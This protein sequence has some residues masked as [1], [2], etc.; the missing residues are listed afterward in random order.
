MGTDIMML[1]H[2]TNTKVEIGNF[3]YI[4]P[5]ENNLGS[6]VDGN[7]FQGGWRDMSGTKGIS[8][9]EILKAIEIAIIEVKT[10]DTE[11]RKDEILSVY[12]KLQIWLKTLP[13]DDEVCYLSEMC[14]EYYDETIIEF[15]IKEHLNQLN[16]KGN[17]K[18]GH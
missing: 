17:N 5:I 15:N 1:S 18:G 6:E 14:E 11:N 10:D 8:P 3:R 2:K 12:W 7:A 4:V 13:E 16:K 9:A